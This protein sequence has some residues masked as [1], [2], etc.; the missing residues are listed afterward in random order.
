MSEPQSVLL[1]ADRWSGVFD[2]DTQIVV[3]PNPSFG[4]ID[5]FQQSSQSTAEVVCIATQQQADQLIAAIQQACNESFTAEEAVLADPSIGFAELSRQIDEWAVE[6]GWKT[7][8]P[9]DLLHLSMLVLTELAEAAEAFRVG[10][11]PCERP[12]MEHMSHA[13]E[14]LADTLIRIIQM[15]AEHNLDLNDAIRRRLLNISGLNVGPNPTLGELATVIRHHSSSL[16]LDPIGQLMIVA[17][18]LSKSAETLK[19]GNAERSATLSMAD[20]VISVFRVAASCEI[21]LPAAVFAK[22]QFNR[23]RPIKHGKL[24]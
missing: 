15:A 5:L 24:A 11:P 2:N 3:N 7:E 22:M 1:I 21:D 14:E 4:S 9:R 18:C 13:A 19:Y 10:N 23:S 20:A 12:G 6:K 17:V 16:G 8:T